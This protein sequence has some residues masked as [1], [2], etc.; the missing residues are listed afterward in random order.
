MEDVPFGI[1]RG[2]SHD[3]GTDD[4]PLHT[5]H[6]EQWHRWK[7]KLICDVPIRAVVFCDSLIDSQYSTGAVHPSDFESSVNTVL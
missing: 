5:C 1:R 7:R 2:Q 3:D 6:I 4:N